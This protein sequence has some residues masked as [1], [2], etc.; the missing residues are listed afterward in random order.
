MCA[1]VEGLKLR[2]TK[3]RR[4]YKLEKHF[5]RPQKPEA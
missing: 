1:V 5:S 3:A 4:S 2:A